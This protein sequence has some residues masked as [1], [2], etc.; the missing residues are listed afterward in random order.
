MRYR[1][2]AQVSLNH[3]AA[4]RMIIKISYIL[5]A[6]SRYTL[7]PSA[8]ELAKQSFVHRLGTKGFPFLSG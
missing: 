2:P 8:S 7:H 4:A 1:V 6:L 5:V 3:K